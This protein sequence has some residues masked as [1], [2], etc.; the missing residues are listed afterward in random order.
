MARGSHL[1][2]GCPE[3]EMLH[4]SVISPHIYKKHDK[5]TDT[6]YGGGHERPR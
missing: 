5:V 2:W 4:G 1:S 3:F 6:T